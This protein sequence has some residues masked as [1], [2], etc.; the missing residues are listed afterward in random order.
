MHEKV[1][2]S[3]TKS[4]KDIEVSRYWKMFTTVLILSVIFSVAYWCES[5]NLFNLASMTIFSRDM[6]SCEATFCCY[7][8]LC[9]QNHNYHHYDSVL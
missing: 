7:Y 1:L 2:G 9:I 5:S 8:A 6:F 3:T 4:K